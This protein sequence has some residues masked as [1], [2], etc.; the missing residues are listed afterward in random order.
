MIGSPSSDVVLLPAPLE[1]LFRV[2]VWTEA[3]VVGLGLR[4]PFGGSVLATAVKP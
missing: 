3:A 2:I 1:A 4:L